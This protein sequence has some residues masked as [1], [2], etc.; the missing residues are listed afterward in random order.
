VFLHQAGT[1]PSKKQA[2]ELL[3]AMHACLVDVIALE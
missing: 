2:D 3:S 1:F